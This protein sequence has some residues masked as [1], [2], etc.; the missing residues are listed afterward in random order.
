MWTSVVRWVAVAACTVVIPTN[1]AP[2]R[3][4]P[5]SQQVTKGW[6]ARPRQTASVASPM[7][8]AQV[9]PLPALLNSQVEHVVNSP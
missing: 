1:A 3:P 2:R 8:G 9:A 7:R 5:H 6:P 4:T